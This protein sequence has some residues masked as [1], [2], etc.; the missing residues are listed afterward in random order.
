MRKI[1]YTETDLE[2][3]TLKELQRICRYYD[4]EY[5]PSWSKDK[6]KKEILDYAPAETLPRTY[7]QKAIFEVMTPEINV[8]TP[9]VPTK[10][11]RVQR[12]EDSMRK[13]K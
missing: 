12:I 6:L 13:D 7:N 3:F 5:F 10:S 11:V 9:T 1:N 4:I 2:G 8:I